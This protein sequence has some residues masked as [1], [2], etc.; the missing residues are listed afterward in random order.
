MLAEPGF[1]PFSLA[2]AQLRSD[3]Y[4]GLYE[5]V[6]AIVTRKAK[7][8]DWAQVFSDERLT[9]ALSNRLTQEAHVVE[10]LGESN[11]F[12]QCLRQHAC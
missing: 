5:P 9:A 6:A 11:R 2:A 8:A 1:A 12:R 4:S 7:F 3:E 10:S